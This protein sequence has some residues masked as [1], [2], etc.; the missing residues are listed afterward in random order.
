MLLGEPKYV[1]KS[2]KNPMRIIKQINKG[3]LLFRYQVIAMDEVLKHLSIYPAYMFF[4]DYYKKKDAVVYGLADSK[5][6]AYELVARM[7]EDSIAK[8]GEC[9][10]PKYLMEI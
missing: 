4:Q 8:T 2:I 3:K 5:K 7:A 9:N 10:I 1:S 6:A